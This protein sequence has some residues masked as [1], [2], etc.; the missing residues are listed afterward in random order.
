RCSKQRKRTPTSKQHRELSF[1]AKGRSEVA[2]IPNIYDRSARRGIGGGRACHQDNH[3]GRAAQLAAGPQF[4]GRLVR[5]ASSWPRWIGPK[6]I[7]IR[8]LENPLPFQAKLDR[9]ATPT[10]P[11]F[12]HES[13]FTVRV[14]PISRRSAVLCFE[15]FCSRRRRRGT[16]E[17]EFGCRSCSARPELGEA[18]RK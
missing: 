1:W 6:I 4:S 17:K 10:L 13:D 11:E 9:Y 12:I 15:Q 3:R 14:L 5:G 7:S 18:T 2:D 16:A 8:L